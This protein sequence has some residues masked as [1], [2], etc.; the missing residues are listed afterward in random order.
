MYVS[1]SEGEGERERERER[2]RGR[3]RQTER[4]REINSKVTFLHVRLEDGHGWISV[5]PI[6]WYSRNGVSKEKTVHHFPSI[7]R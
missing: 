7:D 1:A 5:V 3:E 2:K 6:I 4:E